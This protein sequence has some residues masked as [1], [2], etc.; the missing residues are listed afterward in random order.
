MGNL[1]RAAEQLATTQPGLSKWLKE[2]ETDVGAPLFERTT[3]SLRPTPFGDVVLRHAERMLGDA[4]RTQDELQALQG[5]RLGR[6]VLGVLPGLGAMLMPAVIAHLRERGIALDLELREST[7]DV[8]LP[9]LREHRLDLL[10]ARMDNVALNTG[11]NRRILFTESVCVL[12][13]AAHPL[14]RRQRLTWA[15]VAGAR[16]VL[17]V[18]GSPMRHRI[19]QAFTQAGVPSPRAVL[20]SA[21]LLTNRAMAQQL[22]CLFVT[23]DHAAQML[24]S[25]GSMRRLRLPSPG[26]PTE[27]AVMWSVETLAPQQQH[28]IDALVQ[29]PTKVA[30]AA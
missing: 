6:L 29:A 21:S 13:S 1:S 11:M 26:G 4:A 15:D 24:A 27:V 25:D 14:H 16:W 22:D 18:A 5:G 9:L 12:A 19:E 28:V 17:P 30:V 23:S 10:I 20:E 3:R 8:M 2:V 7:L